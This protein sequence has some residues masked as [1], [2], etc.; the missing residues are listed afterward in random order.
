MGR[1]EN[2]PKEKGFPVAAG[3][4][5]PAEAFPSLQQRLSKDG[6][7]PRSW[8]SHSLPSG[9]QEGEFFPAPVTTSESN[10]ISLW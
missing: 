10:S 6:A 8:P 9:T 7:G 5:V 1:E 2:K 3:G 4:M